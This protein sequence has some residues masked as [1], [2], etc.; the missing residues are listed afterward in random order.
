MGPMLYLRPKN[1]KYRH[2]SFAKD[3]DKSRG[4]KSGEA[5]RRS[6]HESFDVRPG[7]CMEC[8]HTFFVRNE[9]NITEIYFMG[10]NSMVSAEN[11]NQL[12]LDH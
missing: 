2:L 11:T 8:P 5:T 1:S 3:L 9:K 6:A 7:S 4:T 10:K 12:P